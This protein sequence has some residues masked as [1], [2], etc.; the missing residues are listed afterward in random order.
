MAGS[1]F[2]REF[3][4]LQRFFKTSAGP[5]SASLRE[6][7]FNLIGEFLCA[8]A[9]ARVSEQYFNRRAVRIFAIQRFERPARLFITAA[10]QEF[11]GC[12]DARIQAVL[13]LLR[14]LELFCSSNRLTTCSSEPVFSPRSASSA[15]ASSYA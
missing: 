3:Y 14:L 5:L 8:Q 7:I 6:K 11:P 12:V 9:L 1:S 10:F 4:V 13:D 2:E 15:I